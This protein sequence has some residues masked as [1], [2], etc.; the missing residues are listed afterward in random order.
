MEKT[1]FSLHKG[2]L[3]NCPKNSFVSFFQA[4]RKV[5]QMKPS[6]NLGETSR[7]LHTCHNSSRVA[8]YCYYQQPET[9]PPV[10]SNRKT[11][12]PTIWH[13]LL[14]LVQNTSIE[15]RRIFF[16]VSGTEDIKLRSSAPNMKQGIIRKLEA[17]NYGFFTD[18]F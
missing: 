6:C 4:S 14:I 10:T 8:L 11:C 13:K 18:H 9:T 5:A 12:L 2:I 7:I 16:F 15:M 3:H 17:T 1:F